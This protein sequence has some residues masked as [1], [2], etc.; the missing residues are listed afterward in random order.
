MRTKIILFL[1]VCLS[2]ITIN[3]QDT[4]AIKVSAEIKPFVET[5]TKPIA[6]ESADLNGDG[7]KDFILVSEKAEPEKGEFDHPNKLRSLLILVRGKDKKLTEA[8]HNEKVVFCSECGGIFGDPFN[9]VTVGKNTFTV[10]NYGGSA[11][12]WTADY[13]FNYSRID[14]TWQLVRIE[15]L[16][17]HVAEPNKIEHT[18]MTPPKDFGK[19]DIADFDPSDYDGNNEAETEKSSVKFSSVYT[20]FEK[21]CIYEIGESSHVA[22]DCKSVGEYQLKYFDSA[23][24]LHFRVEKVGD[25]ESIELATQSFG[26]VT[27]PGKIEWRLAD[28]KPFAII[29]RIYLH[30]ISDEGYFGDVIGEELMV[31]GLKGFEYI[32]HN[33]DARKTRNANEEVRKFADQ[34]YN[35]NPI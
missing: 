18:I 31:K 21:D 24:A 19:V 17:F 20:D 22:T 26:Y 6:L 4:E 9:G 13:K 14:K 15:Q 2:A 28:G 3:G 7:M 29:M 10:K 34:A 5:G 1:I 25:E 30:K 23:N 32:N 11:W 33:I 35:K 16:S 12:R 8:G 27:K